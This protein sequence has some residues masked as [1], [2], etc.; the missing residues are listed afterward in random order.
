MSSVIDSN[1]AGIGLEI[2]ASELYYYCACP[3]DF[4]IF[5]VEQGSYPAQSMKGGP[6]E[7]RSGFL[8]VGT[9]LD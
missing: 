1:I 9:L 6:T 7:D 2:M 4:V 5:K 3:L 8:K